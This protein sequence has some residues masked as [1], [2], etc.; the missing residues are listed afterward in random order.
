MLPTLAL[1][2]ISTTGNVSMC[3]F[4]RV[5]VLRWSKLCIVDNYFERSQ[6]CASFLIDY[7]IIP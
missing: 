2:L 5:F 4:C 6:V 1:K 3:F 7:F